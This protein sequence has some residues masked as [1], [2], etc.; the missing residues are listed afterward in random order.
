MSFSSTPSFFSL[1]TISTVTYFIFTT[2][3]IYLPFY[4]IGMI[5]IIR[6]TI[7]HHNNN[8][9]KR[10]VTKIRIEEKRGN[11]I[12][13]LSKIDK[14]QG[15]YFVLCSLMIYWGLSVSLDGA[16][17]FADKKENT[18]LVTSE[19]DKNKPSYNISE[20]NSNISNTQKSIPETAKGPAISS[21]GYLVEEIRDGLYWVTDGAYQT[22]FLLTDKGVVA[23]DA[24][25]SIGKNYL[26]A[27][28]EVTDKPITHVIYSHGHIDHIG[29]ASIFPKNAV[30]IAQ[31]N[32]AA[33]LQRAKSVATNASM[34]PPIPSVTF[35]NNYNLEIGNQV[36]KLD[37]HGP[38]HHDGNI[39]I[40]APKQKVL[41]LVDVIFPGWVP[42]PY[43]AVS[44]DIAGYIKAH[45]IV[46]E[47]YEFDTFVGGHLT[48]LGTVEDVK[49]QKDFIS[50]LQIAAAKANNEILL[51]DI[52]KRVGGF[53]NP[54]TVFA[55]YNDAIDEM[56]AQEISPKW[57]DKLGGVRDVIKSH[58]FAMSEAGRI[59]PTAQVLLHDSTF[60]YR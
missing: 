10:K 31:E 40:Y 29:A 26:K 34:V 36:L 38:N 45:D 22:I 9:L 55:K 54:W 15:K 5:N 13:K 43:L 32:T 46:L 35:S 30:Y 27:I 3:L 33:E 52:A 18:I 19:L 14:I 11:K 56:I 59:D 2:P 41:M 50:D 23:V 8:N 7:R 42:F 28:S 21:K 17:I 58:G 4:S 6:K 12:N 16:E 24:P 25:P 49:I 39:F 57:E 1:L 37:Y 53:K 20:D 60:I 51:S 48:R 44:K 47:N